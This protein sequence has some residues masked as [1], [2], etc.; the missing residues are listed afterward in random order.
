MVEKIIYTITAG[1]LKEMPMEMRRKLAWLLGSYHFRHFMD[2]GMT[3]L[4]TE[5]DDLYGEWDGIK[6]RVRDYSDAFALFY[7]AYG[8]YDF[9]VLDSFENVTV[10]DIGAHVGVSTCCFSKHPSV[11]KV[12]SYEPFKENYEQLLLNLKLNPGIPDKAIVENLGVGDETKEVTLPFYPG[13]SLH[14]G[15]EPSDIVRDMFNF[16]DYSFCEK[17]CALEDIKKITAKLPEDNPVLIFINAKGLEE[18]ILR[19]VFSS[20]DTSRLCAVAGNFYNDFGIEQM[21]SDN[22][23][24]FQ[25]HPHAISTGMKKIGSF[26]AT[27]RQ[28]QGKNKE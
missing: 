17:T 24:D 9:S 23:F 6:I 3:F 25:Y 8:Y 16:F 1:H 22:G 26:H 4:L 14:A 10:L 21:F 12:Y 15:L 28:S 2:A 5:S 19:R 7:F 18:K 11:G 27:R 13:A 20:V